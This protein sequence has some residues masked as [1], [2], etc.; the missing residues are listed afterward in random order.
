VECFVGAVISPVAALCLQAARISFE[1]NT[2]GFL[3]LM[4]QLDKGQR[5]KPDP[6]LG[7]REL[8]NLRVLY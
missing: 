3:N 6:I 2:M 4:D 7:R 5:H 8:R 1:G